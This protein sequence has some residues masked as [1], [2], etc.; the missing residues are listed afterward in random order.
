MVSGPVPDPALNLDNLE[1]VRRHCFALVMSMFQMDAIADPHDDSVSAN[2]FESLGML[3]DFRQG[4]ASGF[5]YAGL[6]QWLEKH[7]AAVHDALNEVVPAPV[8]EVEST[9]IDSLPVRLLSALREVGAGPVE[10]TDVEGTLS[11]AVEELVAE[12]GGEEAAT[13]RGGLTMDW[14]DAIDFDAPGAPHVG[15][16]AS[17][18]AGEPAEDAPDGGS[19][20][21]S[22]STDSSIAACSHGTPSPPTSLPSTCSTGTRAPSGRL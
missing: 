17:G 7:A 10:A 21:R 5:S 8:L 22:C 18:G 11:P 13:A 9:F 3:R 19:T 4:S 14:G 16:A 12:G 2:V 20:R 6:E 1:I 15:E